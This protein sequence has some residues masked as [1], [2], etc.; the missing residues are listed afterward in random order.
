M[1]ERVGDEVVYGRQVMPFRF[2]RKASCS[3]YPGCFRLRRNNWLC[4]AL[5]NISKV[6]NLSQYLPGLAHFGQEG[7]LNASSKQPAIWSLVL[8]GQF[9]KHMGYS[10]RPSLC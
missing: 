2:G 4:Q 3:D 9:S 6:F 5:Y 7:M 10:V 8:V 1:R